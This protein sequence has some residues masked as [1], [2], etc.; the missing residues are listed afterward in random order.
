M[1]TKT[2]NVNFYVKNIE[3]TYCFR[4]GFINNNELPK[5]VT[6]TKY[7]PFKNTFILRLQFSDGVIE[8]PISISK[9]SEWLDKIKK[10]EAD[11]I[12]KEKVEEVEDVNQENDIGN[13]EVFHLSL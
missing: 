9:M 7:N 12:K 4:E 8:I 5:S 3:C 1:I 11:D 13:N 10:T 2:K 6:L